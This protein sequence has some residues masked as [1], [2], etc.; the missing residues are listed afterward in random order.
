LEI[1]KTID[2]FFFYKNLGLL[3]FNVD[4]KLFAHVE[5]N[6]SLSKEFNV[7]KDDERKFFLDWLFDTLVFYTFELFST[8][9]L[10]CYMMSPLLIP[11]SKSLTRLS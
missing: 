6:F 5:L 3:F 11:Q 10:Y 9:Y 4:A 8:V 2:Y 7:D 1:L